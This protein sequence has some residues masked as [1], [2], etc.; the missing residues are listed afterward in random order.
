MSIRWEYRFVRCQHYN[1]RWR[2]ALLNAEPV[3]D[4]E[5]G[6]DIAEY[7]N[8]IG[9]EGWEMVTVS[10]LSDSE[11]KASEFRAFFKRQIAEPD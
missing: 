6:P 1:G 3:E 4:F 8:R 2:P 7:S 10:V 9:S 5:N 11:G